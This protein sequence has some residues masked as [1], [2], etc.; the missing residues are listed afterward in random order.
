MLNTGVPPPVQ[1][2]PSL[3]DAGIRQ[4]F[5]V[6]DFMSKTTRFVFL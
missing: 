4:G 2:K 1:D 5:S 6:Y 3:V